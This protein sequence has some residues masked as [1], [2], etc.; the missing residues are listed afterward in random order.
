MARA[1]AEATLEGKLKGGEQLLEVELQTHFGVSGS[2]VREA[3]R[4][5]EEQGLVVIVPRNL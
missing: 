2:P 4:E 1:L 5:L 3:F